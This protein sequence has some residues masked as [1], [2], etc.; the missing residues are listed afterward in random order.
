MRTVSLSEFSKLCLSGGPKKYIFA[1]SDQSEWSDKSMMFI[2][3]YDSLRILYHPSCLVF[4]SKSD[5]AVLRIAG[6][7]EIVL[8]E[9][10]DKHIVF[11][12]I[13]YGDDSEGADHEKYT[14]LI[15]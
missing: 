7:K 2:I 8:H 3:T 9:N 5:S 13:C 15:E 14:L 1:S 4:L 10:A 12:V 11:T 6:I